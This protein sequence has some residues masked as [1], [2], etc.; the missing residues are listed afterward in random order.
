MPAFL[1]SSVYNTFLPILILSYYI[2]SYIYILY[3]V[4]RG[5]NYNILQN[6]KNINF[7]HK[8]INK[9][10]KTLIKHIRNSQLKKRIS[11][12]GWIIPS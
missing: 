8:T 5:L 9:I 3:I 7:F 4:T 2:L 12:V 10:T 1:L 6:F 11:E